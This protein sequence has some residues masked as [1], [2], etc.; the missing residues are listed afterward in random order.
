MST[1]KVRKM[2]QVDYLSIF[3]S[4]SP[5]EHTF[6]AEVELFDIPVTSMGA[7]V[8]DNRLIAIRAVVG[9]AIGPVVQSITAYSD[10]DGYVK[11]MWTYRMSSDNGLIDC[12]IP[13]PI[14]LSEA[15]DI[16]HKDLAK[17]P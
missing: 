2:T 9:C 13:H 5:E 17:L 1:Y 3:D 10:R 16:M 12:C 11:G 7:I 15:W 6:I 8:T 4:F 14:S